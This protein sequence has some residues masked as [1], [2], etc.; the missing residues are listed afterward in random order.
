M[1]SIPEPEPSE[2][3]VKAISEADAVPD[4]GP[5]IS[6]EVK[7]EAESAPAE[8]KPQTDSGH[9]VP[10]PL[11]AL[12]KK[13]LKRQ[14]KDQLWE[15]KREQRAE[16]RREKRKEQREKAKERAKN[17]IVKPRPLPA[18]AQTPLDMDFVIDLQFQDLM[19]PG[20][21]KSTG[22]QLA[23]CYS[24][25]RK[26]RR[27]VRLHATSMEG[28]VEDCLRGMYPTFE[29]WKV[30]FSPKIYADIFPLQDIVYLS[31]DSPHTLTKFEPK[32]VYVIGGIVDKNRHKNLCFNAAEKLGIATA[33]LPLD[34]HVVL[35]TRK[36]L[37]TNHVFE[38]ISKYLQT[39]DW[40][41]SI[42]EVLP[43]RKGVAELQQDDDDATGEPD[44]IVSLDGK[45][46]EEDDSGVEE[47]NGEGELATKRVRNADGAGKELPAA[48]R[49][50]PDMN[51]SSRLIGTFYDLGKHS[52]TV[53]YA[54]HE[55]PTLQPQ[56]RARER[57]LVI[58]KPAQSRFLLCIPL[59]ETGTPMLE[60]LYPG[61]NNASFRRTYLPIGKT[62]VEG[63]I[64]NPDL[65]PL[66]TTNDEAFSDG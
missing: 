39:E 5:S 49:L 63:G 66:R 29:N 7:T 15:A 12:S 28:A 48:K 43:Q 36:V 47:V 26:S 52:A 4:S 35:D 59:T 24:A 46:L 42:L 6:A 61:E 2:A 56:D 50:K 19:S 20:E 51:V 22:R 44:D 17:G 65:L 62:L 8:V 53:D 57:V 31:A 30:S 40:T 37:T 32:K 27:P 55:L 11:Q 13:A 3:P 18:S 58:R 25:N 9:D 33:R 10:P 45:D 60:H 21:L 1:A 23:A 34:A 16:K 41:Q 64:T 38:I 14:K 54:E